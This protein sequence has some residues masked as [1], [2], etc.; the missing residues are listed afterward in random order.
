MK[1]I[2]KIVDKQVFVKSKEVFYCSKCVN[3]SLR[4][5]LLFDENRVCSACH[6]S[7][8]KDN[9]IDWNI[10]EEELRDLLDI[11]RSKNGSYDV[12]VPAS[13]GKDSMYVAHQLKYKYGMHPL[14]VCWAPAMYT[15]IGWSNLQKFITQFDTIVLFPNRKTDGKLSRLGFELVGDPFEPWHHGMRFAPMQTAIHYQIPLVF[16]GENQNAEYNGNRKTKN[17]SMESIEM[18]LE[19][20]AMRNSRGIDVL[21][22]E[23]LK[24]GYFTKQEIAGEVLEGYRLPD[25]KAMLDLGIERHWFSYYKK[26]D[27]QSNYYYAQ[28]HCGFEPNRERSEGTYSKYSS[29]DDKIDG[30]HFYMQYIKFGFGRCT[31]EAAQEIRNHH[32]TRDEGVALVRK[33]DGEFPVKY[34]QEVLDYMNM[35]QEE[36]DFTVNKF[37]DEWLWEK[38]KDSWHLRYQI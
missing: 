5:A 23:G 16:Y 24:Y 18:I 29:L 17:L 14:A 22:E 28:E 7:Y 12:I 31:S 11:H 13:G 30:L 26:W 38:K 2:D 9:Q 25:Q 21:V 1:V 37:R 10:R 32:I 36:F 20:I 3:T 15:N 6:Y 4:P 34:H 19:N 27:P 8:E 35:T 33:Y